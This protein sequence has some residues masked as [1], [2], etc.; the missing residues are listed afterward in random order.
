[1]NVCQPFYPKNLK[2][3]STRLTCWPVIVQ[4]CWMQNV[5]LVYNTV[6]DDVGQ[7]WMMQEDVDLG[8]NLFKKSPNTCM[9]QPTMMGR[10]WTN[11]LASFERGLNVKPIILIQQQLRISCVEQTIVEKLHKI[12]QASAQH[13]PYSQFTYLRL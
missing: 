5:E 7:C 11:M 4:H 12:S 6:L 10:C 2:H 13:S 3:C 9:P 1:M 8:L